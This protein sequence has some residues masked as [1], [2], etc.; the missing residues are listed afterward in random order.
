MVQTLQFENFSC[1]DDDILLSVDGGSVKSVA[2]VAAV[3]FSAASLVTSW[4]PIPQ[5]Q[6]ASKICAVGAIVCGAIA[7]S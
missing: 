1:L 7:A 3:Y 5:C 6:V 4:V 2:G